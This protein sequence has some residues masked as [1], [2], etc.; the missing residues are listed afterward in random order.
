V[1]IINNPDL[2]ENVEVK[3]EMSNEGSVIVIP[4]SVS[5]TMRLKISQPVK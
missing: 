4:T 2:R 1:K 5:F 3:F